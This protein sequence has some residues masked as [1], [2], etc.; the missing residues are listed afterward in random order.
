MKLRRNIGSKSTHNIILEVSDVEHYIGPIVEICSEC[1]SINFK[2]EKPGG[3]EF[4]CYK[5]KVNLEPL[6]PQPEFLKELFTDKPNRSHK[7]FLE[8]IRSYNLLQWVLHNSTTWTWPLLFQNSWPNL[9]WS[10]HFIHKK[11]ILRDLLSFTHCSRMRLWMKKMAVKE[12]E[13]CDP[14]LKG[15]LDFLV[16]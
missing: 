12:N 10:Y 3:G 14:K 2:D 8:N 11:V 6:E 13:R 16:R 1:Q 4:G 7:S 15:E 5:G 9:S